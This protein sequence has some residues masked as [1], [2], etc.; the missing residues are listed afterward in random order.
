MGV[1]TARAAAMPMVPLHRILAA[2]TDEQIAHPVPFGSTMAPGLRYAEGHSWGHS[3]PKADRWLDLGLLQLNP[4]QTQARQG[5]SQE[6]LQRDWQS[7]DPQ[8][9]FWEQLD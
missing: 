9:H 3:Y 4:E 7:S 5:R 8:H 2:S 1:V 6:T